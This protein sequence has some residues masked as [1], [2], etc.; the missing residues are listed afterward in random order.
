VRSLLDLVLPVDCAGC[1]QRGVLAC[2]AG[3]L[4]LSAP[5][6]PVWPRPSPPGL[7]PPWAV[8][9]YAGHARAF[10]LA[11]KENGV[12]GLRRPLGHALAS[13]VR[14]ALPPEDHR[15]LVVVPV[16]SSTSA[17]RRRGCDVVADLARVAATLLRAEGQPTRVVRALRHARKVADSA[18][19]TSTQ[20]S[21]NL[22]GAF[23]LRAG[24]APLVSD[25]RVV[26]VDDLITTGVTLTECAHALRSA[27]A[28][29]VAC[30]TVAAT[31]RRGRPAEG[32]L[33][34]AGSAHYGQGATADWSRSEEAVAWTSS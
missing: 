23:V 34:N 3:V 21:I 29:V 10:L 25:S 16:P 7:P 28:D 2:S 24:C 15:P 30:A 17:R 32:G 27:G 9:A 20:R 13:S 8:A 4:E 31:R 12:V 11:Y 1:G 18:G 5:P 26:V 19:L 6:R 33:H 22:A 14:A